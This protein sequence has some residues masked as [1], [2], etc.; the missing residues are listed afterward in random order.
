MHILKYSPN[1]IKGMSHIVEIKQLDY[2]L[3]VESGI[4]EKSKSGRSQY[5]GVQV[6]SRGKGS[7]GKSY[8]VRDD[9]ARKANKLI[10]R[11]KNTN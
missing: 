3:L 5:E 4:L 2:K 6:C 11:V 9:L 8:I 7:H 10:K 1:S